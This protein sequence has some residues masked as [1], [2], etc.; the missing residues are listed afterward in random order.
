MNYC[1]TYRLS[2]IKTFKSKRMELTKELKELRQFNLELKAYSPWFASIQRIQGD[3][4]I[5]VPG[6]ITLDFWHIVFINQ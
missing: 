1:V 3:R 4:F 5:E 2:F 6:I